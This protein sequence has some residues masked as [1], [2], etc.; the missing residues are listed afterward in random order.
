[1][2]KSAKFSPKTTLA[3]AMTSMIM[4]SMTKVTYKSLSL[5]KGAKKMLDVIKLY[6]SVKVFDLPDLISFEIKDELKKI[7][8]KCKKK[9]KKKKKG[10]KGKKGKK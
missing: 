6:K 5:P 4:A 8:K 10:K 9:K 2:K 3:I 1:L 7:L